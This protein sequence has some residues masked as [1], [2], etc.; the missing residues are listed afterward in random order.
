M[1]LERSMRGLS[2]SNGSTTDY[3]GEFNIA[4]RVPHN[5]LMTM[6]LTQ[7][8]SGDHRSVP[9]MPPPPP[10]PLLPST[11]SPSSSIN[12]PSRRKRRSLK[13]TI[14]STTAA[15]SSPKR[16]K[17]AVNSRRV[18]QEE[19]NHENCDSS[20]S[21]NGNKN[22][23]NRSGGRVK[24]KQEERESESGDSGDGDII[25]A[26]TM[27]SKGQRR[28]LDRLVQLMRRQ[29]RSIRHSD[30]VCPGITHVV[31]AVDKGRVANRTMKLVCGVICGAWILGFDWVERCMAARQWVT[32]EPFE[33]IKDRTSPESGCGVPRK[34]R[35]ARAEGQP[36]L[37]SG[38]NFLFHG[39]FATRE[40]PS[41]E[42]LLVM[43]KEGGG[44][45]LQEE[46]PCLD[47]TE[48]INAS[49][50]LLAPHNTSR[51]SRRSR[52]L[53]KNL[54]T[55][56]LNMI[57]EHLPLLV[58]VD[59]EVRR[60]RRGIDQLR[61]TLLG[62]ISREEEEKQS[63]LVRFIC[64]TWLLDCVSRYELLEMEDYTVL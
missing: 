54:A 40:N 6:M 1:L 18:K 47:Q 19:E 21:S 51:G 44:R 20:C 25:I 53:R 58:V 62:S 37:F 23:G 3:M 36:P 41:R 46:L 15:S 39:D 33:V 52:R 50:S 2:A 26:S 9:S 10:P 61:S 42:A 17:V 56:V 14:S 12:S 35:I 32:E 43:V 24:L 49:P 63:G 13:G 7:I 4:L 29:G 30:T 22:R 8:E 57:G 31:T 11:S 45:V 28:T 55:S 60:T 27:L 5:A 16:R 59:K 64:V 34:A 38:L 48:P